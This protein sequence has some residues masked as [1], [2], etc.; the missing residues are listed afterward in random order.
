VPFTDCVPEFGIWKL[1]PEW[2][3]YTRSSCDSR[4]F[5]NPSVRISAILASF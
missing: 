5:H 3:H 2:E 4:L 1:N